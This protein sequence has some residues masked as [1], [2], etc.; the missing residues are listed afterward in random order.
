YNN[1]GLLDIFLVNGGDTSKAG[2]GV[3]GFDRS[4]PK[5]WNRLYRQNKDGSFTD[6]TQ[7]DGVANAGDKNYGMGVAIGDYDND[8][9]EDIF[10]TNYGQNVLYHNNGN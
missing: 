1:D 3:A 7:E 2:G 10:V 9:N 5:Y 4:N 6:V 8:G